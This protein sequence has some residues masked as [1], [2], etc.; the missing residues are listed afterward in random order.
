MLN[1]SDIKEELRRLTGIKEICIEDDRLASFL[2]S[3]ISQN[4]LRTSRDYI[5]F[6]NSETPSAGA[7][8]ATLVEMISNTESFFFRD[9]GQMQLLRARILPELIL[10]KKP[11]EKLRVLSAACSTGEELYSICIMLKELTAGSPIELELTG[12]D[13][14][15]DALKKAREGLYSPWSFRGVPN[16]TLEKYFTMER[17]KLRL[18]TEIRSMAT[19]KYFNLVE[20]SAGFPAANRES[21]FDLVVCRNVFIYFDDAA[22]ERSVN[23]LLDLLNEDGYLLTGH[24]E[25]ANRHFPGLVT[26][27]FPESFIGK[28]VT[29]SN[30]K[31]KYFPVTEPAM[32]HMESVPEDSMKRKPVTRIKIEPVTELRPA[33][34]SGDLLK[35]ARKAADLGD[36]DLAKQLCDRVL[37]KEPFNH[38]AYFTLAQVANEEGEIEEAFLLFNKVIYLEKSFFAAYIELANI[39]N[40]LGKHKAAEKLRL[41]AISELMLLDPDSRPPIYPGSTVAEI[42]AELGTKS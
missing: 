14:N 1:L 20:G 7:E 2:R 38:L 37:E 41:N 4:Q 27:Q 8:M 30:A 40:Y 15:Q 16:S 25:L 35:Q 3:R 36:N 39:N 18:S 32:A 29:G 5:N 31:V 10:K 34:D 6:L 19:F 23:G 13:I 33:E 28:K 42:I 24:S 26:M 11:D 21:R 22:I 9:H 12:V 17:G